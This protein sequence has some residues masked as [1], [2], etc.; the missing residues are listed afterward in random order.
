MFTLTGSIAVFVL[1]LMLP[2]VVGLATSL[3]NVW[4]K[5]DYE[6]LHLNEAEMR[7]KLAATKT[8]KTK[9]EKTRKISRKSSAFTG[10]H[11]PLQG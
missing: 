8:K 5:N 9:M 2:I 1:T 3:L 11:S 10:L 4:H 7:V 6:F